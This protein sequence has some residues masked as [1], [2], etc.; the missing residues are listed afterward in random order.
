MVEIL[1]IPAIVVD[2]LGNIWTIFA[3]IFDFLDNISPI[4]TAI[5][6]FFSVSLWKRIK[7]WR[8]KRVLS[9]G[10]MSKA[11][12]ISTP[13]LKSII[14]N[15]ERDVAIFDEV[16]LLLH[17]NSILADIGISIITESDEKDIVYD[18]IQI[19]GPVSNKFTNRYFKRYLKGITWIVTEDH[20]ERYLSDKNL[21]TFDYS[22]VKT[23]KNKVEGF[24]VG[25]KFFPYIPSKKRAC[26]F[27]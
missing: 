18:E 12:F 5:L 16:A 20:L 13:K 22:F 25:K 26:H 21:N 11:C 9:F 6:G 27:D 15:K 8:L 4:L 17:V 14:L 10:R 23:T 7:R 1:N 2:F 19:G 3:V 24:K